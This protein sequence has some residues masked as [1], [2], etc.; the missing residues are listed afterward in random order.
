MGIWLKIII[1]INKLLLSLPIQGRDIKYLISP[2]VT[3]LKCLLHLQD[4]NLENRT[5]DKHGRT[6]KKHGNHPTQGNIHL[7][8]PLR[9][10][11]VLF[12]DH[13][14]IDCLLLNNLDS[15]FKGQ[16]IHGLGHLWT[17]DPLMKGKINNWQ[18]NWHCKITQGWFN[19]DLLLHVS[20]C[21][22]Q[23]KI[24]QKSFLV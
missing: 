12:Q 13:N 7:C 22:D 14:Q 16:I 9:Q 6:H 19:T 17:C 24:F 21:Y 23:N 20:F 11:L 5:H 18:G 2:I 4:I 1:G 8:F 15:F 3:S 10:H